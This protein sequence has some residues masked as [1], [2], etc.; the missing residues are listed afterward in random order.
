[1]KAFEASD[2]LELE[3][4]GFLQRPGFSTPLM[5]LNSSLGKLCAVRKCD[6]K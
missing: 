1:M 3:E 2:A 4:V 6:D 5:A